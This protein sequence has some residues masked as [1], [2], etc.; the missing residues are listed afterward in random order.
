MVLVQ[1]MY[2]S[3]LFNIKYLGLSFAQSHVMLSWF[4]VTG[5]VF[6]IWRTSVIWITIAVVFGTI[7][8][9]AIATFVYIRRGDVCFSLSHSDFNF[10]AASEHKEIVVLL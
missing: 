6:H 7:T 8:A 3:P 10:I 5:K 4:F 2:S 1:K 9:V